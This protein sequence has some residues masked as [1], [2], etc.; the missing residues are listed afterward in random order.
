MTLAATQA[1][2]ASPAPADGIAETTLP[3][4]AMV[5]TQARKQYSLSPLPH[6]QCQQ[7]THV[8]CPNN[9]LVARFY[10][11]VSLALSIAVAARHAFHAVQMF[12]TP[13]A[14]CAYRSTA[15]NRS[16][17]KMPPPEQPPSDRNARLGGRCVSPI[18]WFLK[19]PMQ[20]QNNSMHLAP[21]EKVSGVSL[22]LRTLPYSTTLRENRNRVSIKLAF[23][24]WVRLRPVYALRSSA[25]TLVMPS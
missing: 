5:Q 21:R 23:C 4:P 16:A 9:L 1:H 22:P 18:L 3:K 19:H 12:H 2:C 13:S 6:S 24:T 15:T 17:S 7:A 10:R 8:A 14:T 20:S 25:E 11:G